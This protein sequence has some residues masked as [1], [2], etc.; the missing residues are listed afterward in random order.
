MQIFTIKYQ[1]K[2]TIYQKNKNV[3]KKF[4]LHIKQK[5]KNFEAE[6]IKTSSN[7]LLQTINKIMNKMK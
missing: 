4:Q 5:I 7:Y 1:I 3:V 6:Q 2:Q